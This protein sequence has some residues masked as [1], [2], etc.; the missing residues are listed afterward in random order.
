MYEIRF[1][2]VYHQNYLKNYLK[3][4]KNKLQQ[5]RNSQSCKQLQDTMDD[6]TVQN[7]IKT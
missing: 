5:H 1:P 4:L 2:K 3:K 7:Y 6:T